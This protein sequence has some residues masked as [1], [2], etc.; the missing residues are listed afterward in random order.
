MYTKQQ[1]DD[2]MSGKIQ[3]MT[4]NEELALGREVARGKIDPDNPPEWVKKAIEDEKVW[5]EVMTDPDFSKCVNYKLESGETKPTE[6]HLEAFRKDCI[7]EFKEAT[8]EYLELLA[9]ET[10][11]VRK[12]IFNELARRKQEAQEQPKSQD[13]QEP[14]TTQENN[15]EETTKEEMKLSKKQRK[16]LHE[17]QKAQHQSG[18]PET[19][20]EPGS[21]NEEVV[22]ETIQQQPAA[23]AAFNYGNNNVPPIQ[24]QNYGQ[25]LGFNPQNFMV[26]PAASTPA[27]GMV[28]VGA[29][30]PAPNFTNPVQSNQMVNGAV[31]CG[32]PVAGQETPQQPPV[33][34][35]AP[36]QQP[37]VWPPIGNA[38]F[39]M[40]PEQKSNYILKFI[41]DGHGSVK[42]P[43]DFMS[44]LTY[45]AK[46]ALLKS[47]IN[48]SPDQEGLKQ[49][50]I[51][52]LV[53]LLGNHGF[54][55]QLSEKGIPNPE[56]A[57]LVQVPVRNYAATDADKFDMAF[58]VQKPNSKSK[59]ILV[60]F[61]S[62]PVYKFDENCWRW[63]RKV[64]PV[65]IRKD[66][67]AF[68]E[69][70]DV[71]TVQQQKPSQKPANEA[72]ATIGSVLNGIMGNS[73]YTQKITQALAET[74]QG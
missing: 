31:A 32:L 14:T 61:N 34:N 62:F 28:S 49:F 26:D 22:N 41:D 7:N 51:L 16:K 45:E 38:Y 70:R 40:T 44:D 6:E 72:L 65:N 39:S 17:Q 60:L 48:F 46:V 27:P 4:R 59:A 71:E 52:G 54:L 3:C 53:G 74:V 64:F 66:E 30:N 36:Q 20:Q 56:K 67:T 18:Q 12:E 9:T 2:V 15:T 21:S 19:S 73:D 58:L 13:V 24:Q 42:Q 47:R 37:R 57:K 69:Q 8:S 11:V 68:Q 33:T 29:V 50:Q 35:S 63:L 55:N 10:K 43:V 1:Y 25:Q 23:D 5:L